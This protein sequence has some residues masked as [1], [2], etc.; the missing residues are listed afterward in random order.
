MTKTSKLGI[1]LIKHFE[2]ERLEAYLCPANKWT[3]GYGH[4]GSVDGKPVAK[5]MII[6][7]ERATQLL[8]NDIARFENA[9]NSSVKVPLRQNQFDA[10]VAF[11]FNV[12][13]NA[14]RTSTLLRLLNQGKYEEVPAQLLR[15]NKS[16]GRVLAGLVRRRKA[17]GY[18]W[19]TGELKFYF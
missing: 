8:Q 14:F 13:S 12:G 18:L 2:K 16:K 1:D 3:I 17:E 7:S 10:L 6:S 9:V 19:T 5:G 15:W 4:T 11:A